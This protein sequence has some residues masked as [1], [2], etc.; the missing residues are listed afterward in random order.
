MKEATEVEDDRQEENEH[1]HSNH[2]HRV[3]AG[4]RT[5]EGSTPKLPSNVHCI[6]HIDAQVRLRLSL[7]LKPVQFLH[8][9]VQEAQVFIC[10]FTVSAHF[11]V[12]FLVGGDC[13]CAPAGYAQSRPKSC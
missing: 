5:V 10:L 1:R 13:M 6:L 12:I 7:V 4:D 2:G 9:T 11:G 3:A 8:L